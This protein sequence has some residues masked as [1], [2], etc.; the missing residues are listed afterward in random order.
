MQAPI[1]R[2]QVRARLL[3]RA[4]AGQRGGAKRACSGSAATL[5]LPVSCVPLRAS[6]RWAIDVLGREYAGRGCSLQ[7]N[8]QQLAALSGERGRPA[9]VALG[10][11]ASAFVR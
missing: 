11:C 9:V 10:I 6:V 3:T 4:Q 7:R 8:V 1:V 2:G 5:E